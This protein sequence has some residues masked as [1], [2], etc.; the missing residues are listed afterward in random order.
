MKKLI[1]LFLL[2]FWM[3]TALHSCSEDLFSEEVV[4]PETVWETREFKVE[5]HPTVNRNGYGMD[6]LLSG[7]DTIDAAYLTD[8]TV[9]T[10]PF[11]LLCDNDFA[12]A[13]SFTGDWNGTGNPVIFM[14]PDAKAAVVG[15]GINRFNEFL[16]SE[17][18]VYRDSLMA[19][20]VLDL[21]STKHF[22]NGSCTQKADGTYSHEEGFQVQNLIREEYAKL[23]IGN[24]FRPNVGGEF[25]CNADDP[26]QINMQPVF[27]VKTREGAFSLFMV[28]LFK[29]TGSDTQKSTVTWRL[30]SLK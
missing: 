6:L 21:E 30:V 4:Y 1:V 2:S 16:A 14:H 23:V 8:S 10:F 11:D 27:L 7:S 9:Y 5:R 18:N 3:I 28:T 15:Y 25:E 19:D 29:G 20:P 22:H 26:E 13:Q 12:Y 17:L 24:K